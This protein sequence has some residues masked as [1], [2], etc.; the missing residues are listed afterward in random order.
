MQYLRQNTTAT[1]VLGPFVDVTSGNVAETGLTIASGNIR[2]SKNGGA[3][4]PAATGATH[5]SNGFYTTKLSSGNIDTLGRLLVVVNDAAA[6]I[7]WAEY[8]VVN[9]NYYDSLF[10]TDVFDVNVAEISSSATA[11]D[12]LEA[13]LANVSGGEYTS[14][15]FATGYYT[16]MSSGVWLIHQLANSTIAPSTALDRIYRYLFNKMNITDA[17]GELALRDEGDA[18]DI[19]T[20]NITDDG[21]TTIRTAITW[22]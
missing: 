17:S 12:N 6:L 21:T 3:F 15:A 4:G 11:A 9:I 8:Q 19:A 16:H 2:L 1:I 10:S 22:L 5:S 18:A 7:V 20:G 14:A 13:L